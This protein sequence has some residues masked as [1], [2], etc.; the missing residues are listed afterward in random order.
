MMPVRAVVNSLT[1]LSAR[2][3]PPPVQPPLCDTL[4]AAC[5]SDV[6]LQEVLRL[7]AVILWQLTRG[8][9]RF[10]RS[11]EGMR[12][13]LADTVLRSAYGALLD[14]LYPWVLIAAAAAVI[15]FV[16]SQILA[17]V[18][19][20]RD[21]EVRRALAAAL[22][23]ALVFSIGARGLADIEYVRLLSSQIMYYLGAGAVQAADNAP[24]SG[25]PGDPI[26]HLARPASLYGRASAACPGLTL[27]RTPPAGPVVSDPDQLY[28]NDYTAALLFAGVQDIHCPDNAVALPQTFTRGSDEFPGFFPT[29]GDDFAR[30]APEERH[31]ALSHAG[32]GVL[33]LLFGA[34]LACGAILEH[35]LH[36][37]F[38]VALASVL[39]SYAWSRLI[40]FFVPLEAFGTAQRNAFIGV[41]WQ[42][43]LSFFLVGLA[44]GIL[45]LAA[46]TGDALLTAL[47]GCGVTLLV[48]WRVRCAVP[49]LR[50]AA[51]A[52][53][54][55]AVQL[56]H[57]TT[58][59]AS[60]LVGTG[61]QAIGAGPGLMSS[62]SST[63][64]T[65]SERTAVAS[66]ASARGVR[67]QT[68]AHPLLSADSVTT[69]VPAA[70]TPAGAWWEARSYQSE[71]HMAVTPS[72]HTRP[73][74]DTAITTA[75]ATPA[76]VTLAVSPNTAPTGTLTT[77]S[78][79]KD[80]RLAQPPAATAAHRAVQSAARA[81]WDA[82]SP[83][84]DAVSPLDAIARYL[85][86]LDANIPA[87]QWRLL[88]L[89]FAARAQEGYLHAV[90]EEDRAAWVNGRA[91][92][93]ILYLSGQIETWTRERVRYGAHRLEQQHMPT[94]SPEEWIAR[95]HFSDWPASLAEV[96][97]AYES[98]AA[99]GAAASDEREARAR[100]LDGQRRELLA[101]ITSAQ[102]VIAAQE[103]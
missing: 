13:W 15:F 96:E 63:A 30:L 64:I 87:A 78:G 53:Q 16:A 39:F 14:I 17:A 45:Q 100:A 33:R 25:S 35:A 61:R 90:G 22:A 24:I 91:H 55:V 43:L 74:T 95:T 6:F 71:R 27:R 99:E 3:P 18:V 12:E 23:A 60:S 46:S 7:V 44:S 19:Q 31:T 76:P 70:R 69:G 8:L 4:D 9:L 2:Q 10:A 59:A 68:M 20:R 97:A 88:E 57:A 58:L 82:Q 51:A 98:L 1:L 89:Q 62:T 5:S 36:L 26:E 52:V 102:I 50:Y 72:Q 81:L 54:M 93:V 67:G 28:L 21:G 38:M 86:R 48:A 85:A 56:P 37:V 32:L 94:A 103:I 101:A 41:L 29:L 92:Q 84:G 65:T 11:M 49:A 34:F 66:R 79:V 47:L 42:S 75:S 73:I 77:T 80:G 40:A 83:A